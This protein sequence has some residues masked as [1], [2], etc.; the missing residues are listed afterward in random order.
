M[1]LFG[2]PRSPQPAST[3]RPGATAHLYPAASDPIPR[4]LQL[5]E[6]RESL[7]LRRVP[8]GGWGKLCSAEPSSDIGYH[9]YYSEAIEGESTSG[10]GFPRSR[11]HHRPPQGMQGTKHRGER[12]RSEALRRAGGSPAIHVVC[13]ALNGANLMRNDASSM[14]L[15]PELSRGCSLSQG[16]SSELG[17][18]QTS[19]TS[20]YST[21]Q[22]P[23]YMLGGEQVGDLDLGT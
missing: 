21:S 8:L 6:T 15:A 11:P 7:R 17:S 19:E 1:R 23:S 20:F 10:A 4:V 22:P 14:R 12:L 18:S 9:C 3:V 13:R 16:T 5:L 2:S